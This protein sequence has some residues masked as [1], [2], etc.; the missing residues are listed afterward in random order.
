MVPAVRRFLEEQGY[1][2]YEN[3]DGQD[4]F[5]LAARRDR[6][7]GLVELKIDRAGT[8]LYQALRRR[9][10]GDWTAVALASGP[11]ARRLAAASR[12]HPARDAVGVWWVHGSQVDVL[13]TARGWPLPAD[14][15]PLR[16]ARESFLGWLDRVDR[17]EIPPGVGWDGLS[18]EI[19][20]LSGGRRFREWTL[21]EASPPG[22]SGT[23]QR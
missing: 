9:A 17:G 10:W 7:V 6:E 3:P 22:A 2:V 1:R 5:D 23:E 14:A 20:R 16:E 15:G 21:E 18:R 8:V 19:G 12:S 11:A 13:R 4:Y